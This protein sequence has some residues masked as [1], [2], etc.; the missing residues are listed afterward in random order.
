[1]IK[2]K[3]LSSIL[4]LLLCLFVPM[5]NAEMSSTSYKISTTIMSGGGGMM[6][7]ASFT[8]VSTAGQ[9]SPLGHGSSASYR[10]LPG[11][12][13]TLLLAIGVGDVNGD[14][15]VNLEDVIAALQSVTGQT[16]G[17]MYLEADADGDG[18]IGLVEA[19]IVLRKLGGLAEE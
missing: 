12:W 4:V 3:I 9:S 6:S 8:S 11:F 7:S 5:A 15:A 19:I 10:I 18:Q 2:L 17:S 1:M 13:Y 14:G 16:V